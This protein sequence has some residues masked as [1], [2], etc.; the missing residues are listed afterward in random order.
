MKAEVAF[1]VPGV[2]KRSNKTGT[3]Q[4][5]CVEMIKPMTATGLRHETKRN[6]EVLDLYYLMHETTITNQQ[7]D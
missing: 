3:M 5:S 7:S 1:Y 6:L 4:K 2:E